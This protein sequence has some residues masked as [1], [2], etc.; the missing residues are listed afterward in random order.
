[1]PK[2]LKVCRSP[3]SQRELELPKTQF[4]EIMKIAEERKDIISLG[5]GEPDFDTPKHIIEFA[6]KQLDK[7]KTHYTPVSGLSD[8]KEAFAK[9][10]KRENKIDVTPEDQIIVTVGAEEAILLSLMSLLDPGDSALVPHA[11]RSVW[12]R[13]ERGQSVSNKLI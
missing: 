4:V 5:P 8:V 6:K 3:V 7:G 9:K 12:H 13:Q 1:M 10:L 2:K 11:V